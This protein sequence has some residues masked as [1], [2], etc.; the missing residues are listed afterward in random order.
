MSR[1]FKNVIFTVTQEHIIITAFPCF[2][3]EE[4]KTSERLKEF[5]QDCKVDVPKCNERSAVPFR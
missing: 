4:T 3:Y 1:Y 2:T 5:A